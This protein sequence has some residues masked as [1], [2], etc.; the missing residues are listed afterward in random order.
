M[1]SS[2]DAE[3]A[4]PERVA[5][6]LSQEPGPEVDTSGTGRSTHQSQPSPLHG[7]DTSRA[8]AGNANYGVDDGS[9]DGD[10][11][12][13]VVDRT[14]AHRSATDAWASPGLPGDDAPPPPCEAAHDS[15]HPAEDAC[16]N[17]GESNVLGELA[18]S[19]SAVEIA[20]ALVSM[21]RGSARQSILSID[22]P[23]I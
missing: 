21:V 15:E 22:S 16:T 1:S 8:S 6:A 7:H 20:N 2:K 18:E 10:E 17:A 23:W 3:D 11:S 19:A 5:T 9:D 13:D 12:A 14:S 4:A